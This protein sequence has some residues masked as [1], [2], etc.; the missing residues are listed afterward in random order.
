M[1]KYNF[2]LV[3]LDETKAH[4]T[5]PVVSHVT[6]RNLGPNPYEPNRG[7]LL[8]CQCHSFVE[9]ENQISRLKEELDTVLAEARRKYERC[10]AKRQTR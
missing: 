1:N 10:D 9:L 6:V 7:Q 8:T 3:F 5:A 2:D 4:A